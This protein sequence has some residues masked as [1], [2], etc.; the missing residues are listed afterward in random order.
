MLQKLILKLEQLD[1]F[2]GRREARKLE[3]RLMRDAKAEISRLS[4]PRFRVARGR[5]RLMAI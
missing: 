5:P 1:R 3:A 2:L 4:R